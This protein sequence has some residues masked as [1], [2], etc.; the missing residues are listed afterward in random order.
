MFVI[1]PEFV[2]SLNE[3]FDYLDIWDSAYPRI[4][5]HLLPAAWWFNH[6]NPEGKMAKI[7]EALIDDK[8]D[9]AEWEFARAYRH[10]LGFAVLVII[11]ALS[12]N[13]NVCH[14]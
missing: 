12:L 11:I 9:E 8:E 13:L 10:K 2:I 6:L 14:S 5:R 4:E 3:E 1:Q 7:T